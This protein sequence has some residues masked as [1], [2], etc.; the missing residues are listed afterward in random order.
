M[1]ACG[2]MTI[3]VGFLSER[4]SAGWERAMKWLLLSV[5]SKMIEEF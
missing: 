1:V 2:H 5:R 3:T 4:F